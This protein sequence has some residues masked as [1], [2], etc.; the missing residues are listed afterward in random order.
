MKE[1]EIEAVVGL[2][3]NQ[4]AKARAD[5]LG[6][7][8]VD[9]TDRSVERGKRSAEYHT[10][11]SDS[12]ISIVPIGQH[13]LRGIGTGSDDAVIVVVQ[14]GCFLCLGVNLLKR[15][16][17]CGTDYGVELELGQSQTRLGKFFF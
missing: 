6:T 17:M 7:H 2:N 10:P 3:C 11:H 15:Y 5:D 1:P 9:L 4:S 13:V 12:C 8:H 16:R 14:L